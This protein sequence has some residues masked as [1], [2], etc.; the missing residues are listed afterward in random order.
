MRRIGLIRLVVTDW[1][2]ECIKPMPRKRMW[3]LVR[4]AY[5]QKHTNLAKGLFTLHRGTLIST[6]LSTLE[7]ERAQRY[8]PPSMGSDIT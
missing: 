4:T 2:L 5:P 8:T 6:V 3:L 1:R 7:A